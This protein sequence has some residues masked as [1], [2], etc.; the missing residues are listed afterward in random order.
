MILMQHQ[1]HSRSK[2]TSVKTVEI[3]YV[4]VMVET[5]LSSGTLPRTVTAQRTQL[6]LIH[7]VKY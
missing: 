2:Q 4:A 5:F 7:V 1:Y 3:K 6:L